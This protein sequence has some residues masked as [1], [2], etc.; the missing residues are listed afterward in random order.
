MHNLLEHNKIQAA[1]C[2]SHG[3]YL[4]FQRN[5]LISGGR[6]DTQHTLSM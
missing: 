3:M 4:Y 6:W 1:T 5:A 2:E